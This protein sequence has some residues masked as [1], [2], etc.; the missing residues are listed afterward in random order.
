MSRLK[1]I[2]CRPYRFLVDEHTSCALQFSS[3]HAPKPVRSYSVI[4]ISAIFFF[5]LHP[6]FSQTKKTTTTTTTKTTEPVTR[7]LFVLDASSSMLNPWEGKTKI[8]VARTIISEIA[9]SLQQQQNVQ[10]ALR[11]YGH[12]SINTAN[13]CSDSKLEVAFSAGNGALI[14]QTLNSIRPKGITPLALSLEKAAID[15]PSD[16]TARNIVLLVT[17]GEESCGGDPCAIT[18]KMQ[19]QHV[20]LKPFI[21][22]LNL[23]VSAKASMECTGN[24]FN[25]QNPVALRDIMKTV[26]NRIL[27]AAAVRI[28]LLD[29][30]GNPLETDVNMTF[31]DVATGEVKYNFYHTLNYRGIPDTLQMDPVPNYNLVIHTT[32]VIEKKQL[33]FSDQKNTTVNI[34]A[35]QGFLKVEL[36]SSTINNN[37]NSKIKCIIR[38]EGQSETVA[39][40][41]MNTT[42]KYLS[43]TY[44]LEILTLPRLQISNVAITQSS[45]TTV[46]ID[47]PGLVSITKTFPGYGSVFMNEKGA[48]VKIYSL[49]EN[50]SNELVGLQAGEYTVIYRP[51]ASKKTTESI[52]KTFQIKSGQSTQLKL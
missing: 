8:D 52:T 45:T 39:V 30:D 19:Q 18:L 22:G 34:P 5:S 35:S 42:V 37:L 43:G 7:I 2:S 48:L 26:V 23:D 9:D 38:K 17:D 27:S 21:I 29:A 47:V 49:N 6:V 24:Y 50:L 41:D 20:Y 28:N 14:R 11:V 36:S 3:P 10:T 46:K 15:F 13:D 40:Q 44:D 16:P 51:K 25:A 31:Y 1:D 32:P 33:E 12:Q 4:L